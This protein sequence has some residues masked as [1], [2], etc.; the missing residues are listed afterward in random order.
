MH[1][2][3]VKGTCVYKK[4]RRR[5]KMDE[6]QQFPEG[7][8]KEQSEERATEELYAEEAVNG[9]N[10]E[11]K[12]DEA[13]VNEQ[14]EE[15][16][17]EK[18][19]EEVCINEQTEEQ[20]GEEKSEEVCI[21]VQTEK[22]TVEEQ[23]KQENTNMQYQQPV[24]SEQSRQMTANIQYQQPI[25]NGQYQ[26][27]M[28][29]GYYR[30]PAVSGQYQQPVQNGSY[31]QPAVNGQYQQ[32]M[33]NGRYQQNA[34][35]QFQ[36]QIPNP[37]F[38]G[39][40]MKQ[41]NYANFSR[42]SGTVREQNQTPWHGQAGNQVNG[43]I[44]NHSYG[45]NVSQN[46]V[47]QVPMLSKEE[48]KKCRHKSELRWYYALC[49]LNVFLIIC[50]LAFSVFYIGKK[51]PD[52]K[53]A[54]HEVMYESAKEVEKTATT[55]EEKK[56]A[57]K[58]RKEYEKKVKEDK[59]QEKKEK[60]EQTEQDEMEEQ[61]LDEMFLYIVLFFMVLIGLPFI[62]LYMYQQ[63][64][65]VSIRITERNFPEVYKRVQ[66]YATMLGM[67]KVPEVYIVQ[68]NG[69]LNAFSSFIV[70]KQ[71]IEIYADIFEIAY[72][73]HK[74]LDTIS[75]IIA[76]E[77][78]HIHYKHATFGYA[79]SIY[80]SKMIP[81]LGATASRAREYSCDRLAQRLTGNDGVEAMFALVAGKHL[82]K[83]VDKQDY[84]EY[85]NS[86]RGFFVWCVNLV[87]DHPIMTKR[88][89]A[90]MMKEGSGKLY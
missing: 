46:F 35:F 58:L 34:N 1:V 57:K 87:A 79:L 23:K 60:K 36:P 90:L 63:Y 21:N 27:P 40:N 22:E 65:T 25:V 13:C 53:S 85:A 31:R 78:A 80:F 2:R 5:K 8:K 11:K 16:N 47:P 51:M 83:M 77:M 50:M 54:F 42:G 89:P 43:N 3:E 39:Q 44:W 24:L 19:S 66:Q 76:H 29:N 59:K 9:F 20:T 18:K 73:E 41:E 56:E 38:Q 84:L 49:V 6:K 26:Q 32:P 30:Q 67:K 82:Y 52:F 74:D 12:C 17:V 64:R 45:T 15:V 37:Q 72:R 69:I 70:R 68:Q 48:I 10:V 71:Y 88:I 55:E 62:V 28:Q 75:F 7:N 81:I 33:Q 86:V 61:A 4:Y 14:T